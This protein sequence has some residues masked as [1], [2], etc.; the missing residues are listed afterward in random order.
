MR[1][2]HRTSAFR[3]ERY[4]QKYFKTPWS[5]IDQEEIKYANL[6]ITLIGEAGQGLLRLQIAPVG[7]AAKLRNADVE[8]SAFNS[9]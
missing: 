3:R 1:I 6:M 8:T 2:F 5:K 4:Q 7:T 9:L